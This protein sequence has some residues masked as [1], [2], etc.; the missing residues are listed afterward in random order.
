MSRNND[1]S[2]IEFK[3]LATLVMDIEEKINKGI[4]DAGSTANFRMLVLL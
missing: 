1:L 2:C 3:D 4:G